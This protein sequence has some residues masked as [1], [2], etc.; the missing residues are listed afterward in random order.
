[1]TVE[2]LFR[3]LWYLLLE[4]ALPDS[5]VFGWEIYILHSL[6][7]SPR[8]CLTTDRA[9]WWDLTIHCSCLIWAGIHPTPEEPLDLDGLRVRHVQGLTALCR[10]LVPTGLI[11]DSRTN[12]ALVPMEKYGVCEGGCQ[13]SQTLTISV[14]QATTTTSKPVGALSNDYEFL[15]SDNESILP[16]ENKITGILYILSERGFFL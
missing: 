1:M 12:P 4:D 10:S 5:L 3:L 6:E 13:E 9:A 15:P 14:H 16:I 2:D 7:L 8:A 11:L